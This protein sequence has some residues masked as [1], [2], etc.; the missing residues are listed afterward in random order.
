MERAC[1]GEVSALARTAFALDSGSS[2]ACSQPPETGTGSAG[3]PAR[4]H[5]RDGGGGTWSD[6]DTAND[7]EYGVREGMR[8]RAVCQAG[9]DAR[10]DVAAQSLAGREQSR[11]SIP[12]GSRGSFLIY[13]FGDQ[14]SEAKP[15]SFLWFTVSNSSRERG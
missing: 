15:A 4:H 6:R 12:R 11:R 9:A 8:G 7:A 3:C 10:A 1:L 13:R 2:I 5:R 14:P